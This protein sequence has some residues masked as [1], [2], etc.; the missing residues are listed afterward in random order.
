MADSGIKKKVNLGGRPQGRL[1]KI[2]VAIKNYIMEALE[3]GDGAT[4]FFTKLKENEPKAFANVVAKLLPKE[5]REEISGDNTVNIK[6]VYDNTSRQDNVINA[7]LVTNALP[8]N[9]DYAVGSDYEDSEDEVEELE[10]KPDYNAMQKY[11]EE[12]K[13]LSTD[14]HRKMN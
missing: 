11:I 14:A 3:A 10:C 13:S 7:N 9:A 12:Q 1:N 6:V 2:P 4:A 8:D 5:I